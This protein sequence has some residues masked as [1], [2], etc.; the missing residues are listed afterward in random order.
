MSVRHSCSAVV[1]NADKICCR[2]Q[3][4][5]ER[6]GVIIKNLT[7]LVSVFVM[8]LSLTPS[9]IAAEYDDGRERV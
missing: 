9:V 4:D 5:K 8:C 6:R 1:V 7:C 3:N 2:I